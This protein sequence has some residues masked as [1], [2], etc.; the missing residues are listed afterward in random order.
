MKLRYLNLALLCIL[1]FSFSTF[2]KESVKDEWISVRSKNFFLIGDAKEK[3][4]IKVATKLEQFREVFI[5]HI[6]L[7]IVPTIKKLIRQSRFA[8][9]CAGQF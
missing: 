9:I 6:V 3:D 8:G 2:A 5:L 7:H 4:I 1:L